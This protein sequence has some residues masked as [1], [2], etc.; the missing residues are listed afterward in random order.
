[1]STLTH[2]W[3]RAHRDLGRRFLTGL[4]VALSFT[5]VAYEWRSG[6]SGQ[7]LL[8]S[9]PDEDHVAEDLPL[10]FVIKAEPSPTKVKTRYAANAGPIV[11]VEPMVVEPSSLQA[12]T[13]PS[14]PH[15]QEP[16]VIGTER[17][18]DEPIDPGPQLWDGVE[19]RPYF[20]DCLRGARMDLDA[21]T[22]ERI[23]AHL[24]RHFRV[25]S[26]MRKREEFT[27][28]TMEVTSTGVIGRLVCV[29]EPSA[30]VKAEIERVIRALPELMPG[31][32]N[33]IAVPVIYQLPFRVKRI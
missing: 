18:P 32:Q 13:V 24:Q 4:T 25:P 33:G 12:S 16:S 5:L 20:A 23:D 26:D 27:V 3:D 9:L 31:T 14:P 17:L 30:A 10:N 6:T 2:T 15:G 28:I 21:C 22:E 29:P 7:V 19:Q 11:P 8:H 1:M